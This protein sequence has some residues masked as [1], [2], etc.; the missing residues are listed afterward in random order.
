MN[1]EPRGIRNNNP[2]NIRGRDTYVWHGQ[3]GVDPDN[4][5]IFR[6]PVWGIRAMCILLD[7]YYYEH[8]LQTIRAMINR[9]APPSENVTSDYVNY[10]AT[11]CGVTPDTPYKIDDPDHI[12]TF[13]KAMIQYENGQQPYLTMTI[14]QGIH[15]AHLK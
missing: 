9:W 12:M 14:E 5:C 6:G 3:T 2:G 8:G 13:V 11:A 4:F 10:M 7:N 1:D 15:L